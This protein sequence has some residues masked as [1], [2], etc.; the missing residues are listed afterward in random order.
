V[1]TVYLLYV[2]AAGLGL[3]V[4]S[5]LNVV[6]FRYH[7]GRG[8]SGRSF[9]PHCAHKLV[10]YDLVPVVSFLLLRGKCRYCR[11]KISWQ[12]PLVELATALS[13]LLAFRE[14]F[15]SPRDMLSIV[16][17][18]FYIIALPLLIAIVAYDLKHKI[19]PDGLVYS[20]VGLSLL[21]RFVQMS[22]GFFATSALLD[23]AAGPLLF[24]FFFLFWFGS[25]GKWMGLGDAKL[26]LGI[27]WMLGLW[28]GVSAVIFGFWFGAVF[29]ILSIVL[30]HM[31]KARERRVTMKSE[32]PFAPFLVAGIF[33][34][35]FTHFSVLSL[36]F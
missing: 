17:F 7:S 3:A 13:F 36:G 25:D 6:V 33:A 32:V 5:F 16:Q 35:T 2:Y 14:F 21:F 8:V 24:L 26:G 31:L 20:F 11:A 1:S 23:L 10:W 9:C 30:S 28:G 29:G 15:V 4:G 19:I 27:G 34:A 18:S 22:G 12:Y